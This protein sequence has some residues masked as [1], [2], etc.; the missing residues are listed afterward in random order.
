MVIKKDPKIIGKMPKL[1]GEFDGDQSFPN[2]KLPTPY[3]A[4]NGKPFMKI[5]IQM[6]KIAIIAVAALRKNMILNSSS[7]KA[8]FFT[9]FPF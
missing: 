1:A 5:K 2:K 9:C 7:L 3:L 6:S 8:C 4:I